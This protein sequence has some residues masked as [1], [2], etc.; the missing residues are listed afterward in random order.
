M[1]PLLTV[2][3]VAALAIAALQQSDSELLHEPQICRFVRMRSSLAGD[4]VQ[5]AYVCAPE[6]FWLRLGD[7][8]DTRPWNWRQVHPRPPAAD[9]SHPHDS[10]RA[11]MPV[12]ANRLAPHPRFPSA[13]LQLARAHDLTN[14]KPVPKL[15][16]REPRRAACPPEV[17]RI[18][19]TGRAAPRDHGQDRRRVRATG[20]G[21]ARVV[22]VGAAATCGEA[23]EPGPRGSELSSSTGAL[24]AGHL[25]PLK[26]RGFMRRSQAIA[27][28]RGPQGVAVAGHGLRIRYA[29]LSQT[30]RFLT[31]TR[32]TLH[33][34]AG[35]TGGGLISCAEN[36]VGRVDP[37]ATHP[38]RLRPRL[39]RRRDSVR[40][41]F[42]PVS[43]R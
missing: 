25:R 11:G 29:S 9:S 23:K 15:V 38:R 24:N 17:D 3:V 37:L 8:H 31:I 21:A 34:S 6:H 20:G 2:R 13:R 30:R 19:S 36:R 10:T 28:A 26:R 39:A 27:R 40:R 42:E 4:T 41:E 5:L 12:S 33:P 18:A 32:H 14:R 1:T 35:V 16:G 7:P 22:C 43:V